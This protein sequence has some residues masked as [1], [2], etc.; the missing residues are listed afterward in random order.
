MAK[1]QLHRTVTTHNNNTI[2]ARC[3]G[4]IIYQTDAQNIS[5]MLC[6]TQQYFQCLPNLFKVMKT[7]LQHV[8]Y[9]TITVQKRIHCIHY[10]YHVIEHDSTWKNTVIINLHHFNHCLYV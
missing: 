10:I 5:L 7:W 3:H 6:A 1:F 8:S 4:K 9:I 2:M